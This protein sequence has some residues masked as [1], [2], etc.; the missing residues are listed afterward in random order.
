[1][2]IHLGP[3]TEDAIAD[4]YKSVS[5]VSYRVPFKKM[6]QANNMCCDHD[7]DSHMQG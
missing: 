3:K 1:M 4:L 5:V 6:L 2:L 7:A